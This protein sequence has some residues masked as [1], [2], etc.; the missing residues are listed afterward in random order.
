MIFFSDASG[1]TILTKQ[2]YYSYSVL[3]FVLNKYLLAFLFVLRLLIFQ[4]LTLNFMLAK[5]R[6]FRVSLL[7]FYLKSTTSLVNWTNIIYFYWLWRTEIVPIFI[8]LAQVLIHRIYNLV[9]FV[10]NLLSG[11]SVWRV[12]VPQAAIW[13]I[14]AAWTKW[15]TTSSTTPHVQACWGWG[16]SLTRLH[17][18]GW[19]T[20]ATLQS[21]QQNQEWGWGW[22]TNC[23]S[24]LCQILT[25]DV[26]SQIETVEVANMHGCRRGSLPNRSETI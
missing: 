9:Y 23:Q 16:H 1:Q 6:C 10:I 24:R 25:V 4:L 7:L 13:R 3:D 22:I 17:K 14:Q 26:T 20:S 19:G 18:G 2:K 11:T 5:N 8:C 15:S 21:C 12:G